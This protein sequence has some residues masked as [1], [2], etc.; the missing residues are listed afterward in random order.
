MHWLLEIG[1][2][3]MLKYVRAKTARNNSQIFELQ[4]ALEKSEGEGVNFYSFMGLSPS[5]SLS[6]SLIHI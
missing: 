6:L 5:A 3:V 2:R 1:T 4:N